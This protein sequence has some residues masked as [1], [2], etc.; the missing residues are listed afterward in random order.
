M[1]P[2]HS[3]AVEASTGL[4]VVLTCE[5]CKWANVYQSERVD[6]S[7]LIQDAFTHEMKPVPN[8]S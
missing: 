3:V 4:G 6:I 1:T 5:P 2:Q 7:T 8:A